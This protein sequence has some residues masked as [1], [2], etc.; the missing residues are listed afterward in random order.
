MMRPTDT[1]ND[2]AHIQNAFAALLLR[3]QLA[4]ATPAVSLAVTSTTAATGANT[5]GL[6]RDELGLDPDQTSRNCATRH[7]MAMGFLASSS[8]PCEGSALHVMNKTYAN[9]QGGGI[10]VGP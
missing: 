1:G 10:V 2:Q 5:G 3:I 9:C 7:P 6:G 4:A 8:T